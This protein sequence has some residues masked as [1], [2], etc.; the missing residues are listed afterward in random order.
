MGTLEN[1]EKKSFSLSS[2]LCLEG[3]SRR[4]VG[5]RGGRRLDP[6]GPHV[7][8]ELVGNLGQDVFGEAGHAQDVIP[9]PVDVVSEWDE[10]GRRRKTR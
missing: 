9:R 5:R 3:L 4:R 10:L 8:E 6:A 2:Y 1:S 7:G